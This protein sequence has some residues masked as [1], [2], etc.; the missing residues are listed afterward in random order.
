MNTLRILLV[1]LLCILAVSFIPGV[2]ALEPSWT[3]SL[4]NKST[5]SNIAVSSDGSTIIVA[6][7]TLWV[8]S[9]YGNLIKKETYGDNVVL[10]PS[11]RFAAS[12]FGGI[13]YFFST[14]LTTGTSDP[15]QLTKM[16]DYEFRDPVRSIGITD[17][18]STVVVATQGMGIYFMTPGT[19]NIIGNDQ[20]YNHIVRIS[21]NGNR[22]AG[23]SADTV[24]LY[25]TN[26]KI[27]K[28]YVMKSTSQPDFAFLSQTVPLM[29]FNNG[30]SI[31]SFD[32]SLGTEIWNV[33]PAGNL[34]SL[35]MTPSGSYVA[36]GTENGDIL[37]Y[38][39]KGNQSWSY[40]SN[41]ENSLAA[42]ISKLTISKE[43]GLVAAASDNGDVLF[44]N[45]WGALLGSYRVQD[46]IRDIAMSQDGSIVL[47]ASDNKIYAFLTGYSPSTGSSV[48][49][50]QKTPEAVSQNL[51]RHPVIPTRT[52]ISVPATITVLPTEYSIIRTPTRSPPGLFSGILA[53]VSGIVLYCAPRDSEKKKRKNK[54]FL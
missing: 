41:K 17:D 16:W 15:N 19:R 9:K 54:R 11:G 34:N 29:V 26:G 33:R 25:N 4:T 24:R 23:I 52:K 47:V 30:A 49:S 32:L 14:P 53:L 12:S 43:G 51:T 1:V 27:S 39:D 50:V 38:D 3:Y 2:Q 44:L 42:G 45:P 18:G 46:K 5:I 31:Q 8:F 48:L 22:I 40:S 28:S 13:I 36:A 37:R 21:A 6:A 35:A 10:T 20:F 7:D